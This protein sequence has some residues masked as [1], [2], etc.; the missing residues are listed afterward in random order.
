MNRHLQAF[1]LLAGTSIGSFAARAATSVPLQPF[2]VRGR[3][4]QA[5][6]GG[7]TGTFLFDT[8]GGVTNITPEFAA[9]IGCKPWGQISGFTMTGHRLDMKRCDAQQ[10]DFGGE[11]IPLQIVGVFDG[12][13]MMPP[14]APHLDGTIALDAFAGRGLLFSLANN[15]IT[16]LGAKDLSKAAAGSAALPLHLVRDAEGVALSVNLPVQT[17]D[18]T[19]WFEL[20]SGNT[21]PFLL[22]GEHLAVLLKLKAGTQ[23]AQQLDAKLAD[24]TVVAGE[25]KVLNLT[26]D[27]NIGTSFLQSHDVVLD[28]ERC[29]AWVKHAEPPAKR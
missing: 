17:P 9:A 12:S 25:A 26:L 24:S 6:I 28:L 8:G 3:T 13:A 19:A 27:G 15:S 20:D 2:M 4:V 10:L 14:D 21:S 22:V 29:R 11:R 5:M 18:G 1:L 23:D 16:L 7:K